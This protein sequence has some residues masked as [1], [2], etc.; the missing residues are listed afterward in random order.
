MLNLFRRNCIDVESAYIITLMGNANS[1]QFSARC[2]ESC[3]RANMPYKIWAAYNGHNNPI[4][5]PEHSANS[6]IMSMIKITDHYLT[7]GEVAC[8]LSHISLWAHCVKIDQPI[9][10][11]EHDAVMVKAFV[12]HQSYNSIVYLGG[13]EWAERNWPILPIPPHASEGPNYHFI[14]R[15]H[16]YSIDPA[17]AKNLLSY[18]LNMGICAPLDIMIRA[19]IFHITHQG[20]YAYDIATDK[21]NTTIKARPLEGRTTKRNDR[22]AD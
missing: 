5:E 22:L 2:Q 16:A 20:L 10:I 1:E 12:Q 19:D 21:Q 6:D 3:K 9:V 18:A 15:A 8:A 11:L 7:R 14:C 13:S 17:I 4:T